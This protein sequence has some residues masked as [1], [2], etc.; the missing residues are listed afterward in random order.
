MPD[1]KPS[2]EITIIEI[3]ATFSDIVTGLDEISDDEQLGYLKG[4]LAGLTPKLRDA[5]EPLILKA[6]GI[7]KRETVSQTRRQM[8]L[9]E[10][11]TVFILGLVLLVVIYVT[12]FK[13]PNP[14]AFQKNVFCVVLGLAAAATGAILPGFIKIESK[15]EEYWIR[16]GGAFA[17]LVFVLIFFCR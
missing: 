7:S 14:T 8:E 6:C 17:L 11:I 13:V 1:E 5:V 9:W 3:E 4:R 16:A 15:T 2:E 10:K 12:A